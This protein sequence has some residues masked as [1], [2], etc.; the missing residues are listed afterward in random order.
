M[1]RFFNCYFYSWA[2]H[3]LDCL[4]YPGIYVG[5][6]LALPNHI[7]YAQIADLEVPTAKR[8]MV[9]LFLYFIAQVTSLLMICRVYE[10]KFQISGIKHIAF[11]LKHQWVGVQL[12]L[13][14]WMFYNAQT[15]LAHSGRH[16]C[17]VWHRHL[18]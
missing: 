12:K 7:Y 8:T 4:F 11:V 10:V 1:V 17:C 2:E 16:Q 18:S 9:S 13:I 15:S 5:I 3:V 14:L 6:T